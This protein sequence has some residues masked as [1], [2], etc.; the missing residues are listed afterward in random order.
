MQPMAG[1]DASAL[2]VSA[3]SNKDRSRQPVTSEAFWKQDAGKVGADEVFF[4]K[5]FSTLGRGREKAKKKKASKKKDDASSESE[6]EGDE[7]EIWKALV[8]SRPELDGGSDGGIFS[9]DDLGSEMGD[10]DD[11]DEDLQPGE[12][13]GSPDVVGLD[14]SMSLEEDD[15]EALLDSDDEVPSDIEAAFETELQTRKPGKDAVPE[16][17]EEGEKRSKKRRRLKSLPTFASADDYAKM[18]DDGG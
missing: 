1:G 6:D 4:H 7:D 16:M 8:D 3:Y 11:T 12:D 14:D 2:L 5:Y 15:D 13:H 17:L 18:I 9:D 10:L